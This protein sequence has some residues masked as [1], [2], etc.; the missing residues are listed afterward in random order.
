MFDVKML[1]VKCR[2][3]GECFESLNCFEV[4]LGRLDY[5]C[6]IKKGKYI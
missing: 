5:D 2:D 6:F 3:C 1:R 4:F